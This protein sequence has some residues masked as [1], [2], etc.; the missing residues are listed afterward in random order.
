MPFPNFLQ[1]P[2]R[3]LRR[4]RDRLRNSLR[5]APR[6]RP[7]TDTYHSKREENSVERDTPIYFIPSSHDE[8]QLESE[9]IPCSGTSGRVRKDF[10]I[11]LDQLK[12]M[13]SFLPSA[14]VPFQSRR[15]QNREDESVEG[16]ART[17]IEPIDPSHLESKTQV[18]KSETV[19]DREIDP[20]VQ[21]RT[22]VGRTDLSRLQPSISQTSQNFE[23]GRTP[24][25]KYSHSR[26][27][28]F[29]CNQYS[30]H[31]GGGSYGEVRV[32]SPNISTELHVQPS[33]KGVPN[34]YSPQDDLVEGEKSQS[35]QYQSNRN[36]SPLPK[37]SLQ[38]LQT[39]DETVGEYVSVAERIAFFENRCT[40][41][42]CSE[43]L[44]IPIKRKR[45]TN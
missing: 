25:S 37:S 7:T 12:R 27:H 32:S 40:N 17:R 44:R 43:A 2:F 16:T 26:R 4:M 45:E 3:I 31:T 34:T 22:F 36:K 6:R 20:D 18:L 15:E 5:H 42:E 11:A 13:K 30:S 8:T 1:R 33:D 39:S 21:H 29:I 24:G 14:Y 28:T 41:A 10:H 19:Q 9:A 35:I 23:P 38:S